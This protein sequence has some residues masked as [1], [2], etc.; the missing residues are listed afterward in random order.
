MSGQL[1]L[2]KVECFASFS[3]FA[4]TEEERDRELLIQVT[5]VQD[6]SASFLTGLSQYGSFLT[7]PDSGPGP[8]SRSSHLMSPLS[9]F[10]SPFVSPSPKEE[11]PS[12]HFYPIDSYGV[13]IQPHGQL[14]SRAEILDPFN[15]AAL[16][17]QDTMSFPYQGQIVPLD[18][19]EDEKGKKT[20]VGGAHCLLSRLGCSLIG[21]PLIL[22]TFLALSILSTDGNVS[23]QDGAAQLV[24]TQYHQA[25]KL[26]I[27]VPKL[28]NESDVING[29]GYFLFEYIS[30]PF[31]SQWESGD[32][33]H[34][35]ADLAALYQ[36][37]RLA[38][39]QKLDLD[40]RPSNLRRREDGSIVLVDFYENIP[41]VGIE[42]D[43]ALKNRV[44]L[45]CQKGDPIYLQL[46]SAISCKD[47]YFEI[48]VTF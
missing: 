8:R 2:T 26:G 35:N 45:F 42:L 18:L 4:S 48:P 22:K 34:T 1:D 5:K 24:L 33:I 10:S 23:V 12:I 46:F 28:Y 19:T 43:L 17:I 20:F 47:C 13:P 3:A 44:G 38:A 39:C 16:R 25:Q 30:Q 7:R 40:L 41:R 37:F 6:T 29:C 32:T 31:Y 14:L 36:M 21:E 15:Q 27:P 11:L 9:M